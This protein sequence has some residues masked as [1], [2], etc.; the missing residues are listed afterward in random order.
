MATLTIESVQTDYPALAEWCD[1]NNYPIEAF[2]AYVDNDGTRSLEKWDEISDEFR[3]AYRGDWESLAKYADDLGH[4]VGLC[5]CQN[6]GGSCY[7]SED[8]FAYD[9]DCEGY[10]TANAEI[11]VYVFAPC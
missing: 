5:N 6:V 3:D 1:E 9:L 10:W 7:F 11:G 4:E 2:V 8:K